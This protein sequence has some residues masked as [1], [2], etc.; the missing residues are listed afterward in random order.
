MIHDATGK[1]SSRWLL[2]DRSSLAL[3]V[4]KW[5]HLLRKHWLYTPAALAHIPTDREPH[6]RE[7]GGK[8]NAIRHV[9]RIGP[10]PGQPVWAAASPSKALLPYCPW[11]LST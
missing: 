6:I 1:F 7:Y 10:M 11:S 8:T 2:P 9:Q 3:D 5:L 4:K